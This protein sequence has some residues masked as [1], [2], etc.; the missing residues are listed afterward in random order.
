[1]RKFQ[2]T[3]TILE[4]LHQ[5]DLMGDLVYQIE[6]FRNDRIILILVLPNLHEN[7]DHILNPV[8]NAALIQNGTETVVYSPIGFWRVPC[9]I[10]FVL[11]S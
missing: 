2:L 7:S 10:L 1:M 11:C 6:T 3:Q 4:L 9:V 5:L 8:T